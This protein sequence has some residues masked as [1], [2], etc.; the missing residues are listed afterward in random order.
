VDAETEEI[1]NAHIKNI[2]LHVSGKLPSRYLG[3]K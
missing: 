3:G 2:E 1:Y